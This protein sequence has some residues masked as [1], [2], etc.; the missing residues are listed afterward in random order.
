V[1]GVSGESRT[2]TTK[3]SEILLALT[4]GESP[5]V[6]S[7]WRI[8]AKKRDFYL[9]TIGA[10]G[11]TMHVSLHGP[12]GDFSNHRFHLRIDR[13]A[14]KDAKTGGHFVQHKVPGRGQEFRGKQ[15]G[16]GAFHVARLRWRWHLQRPR[17]RNAA[18][19]GNAP[20][21][22]DGQS[23]RRLGA[24]LNPN[25][26]W[27][28]D[29]YVSYGK[30]YWPMQLSKNHGDPRLGPVRNDADMWLT[31]M[32]VHRAEKLD[33]SPDQLVP[34][35]PYAGETPNRLTCGGLGPAGEDDLY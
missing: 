3:K 33:P 14:V 26:A 5:A 21:I 12:R 11:E 29:V 4:A 13:R 23:G 10:T 2:E 34:R 16:D 28:V 25:S 19:F 18:V 1:C 17:Y 20:D 35:L 24:T 7:I 15:V 6:G 31:A 32:S 22:G 30:P 9:D 8:T 27:D